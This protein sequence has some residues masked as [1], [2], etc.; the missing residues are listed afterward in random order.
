MK[1]SLQFHER[2]RTWWEPGQTKALFVYNKTEKRLQRSIRQYGGT[3]Q[4]SR[5]EAALRL[6]KS[7]ENPRGLGRWVW[8][9]FLGK[10]NTK[11]RVITA[12]RPNPSPGPFTVY[13]QHR[14]LFNEINKK[15]W[16]P[17]QQMLID[18]KKH[19]H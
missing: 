6:Q 5:G 1:K 2:I 4:F 7:G 14:R 8:Q 11:L 17:C 15:D 13:A 10:N 12:Y 3:A 18:L 9:K 19:I 16:E